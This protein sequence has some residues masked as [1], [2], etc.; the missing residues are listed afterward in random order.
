MF[1]WAALLC[2]EIETNMDELKNVYKAV[3][4]FSIEKHQQ[5]K[6]IFEQ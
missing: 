3:K 5:L 1:L 2:Y 4:I 6:T